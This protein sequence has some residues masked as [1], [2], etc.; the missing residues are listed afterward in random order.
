MIRNI[1]GK[2]RSGFL[3]FEKERFKKD[4]VISEIRKL[5]ADAK[6]F[7]NEF[8]ADCKEA[9]GTFNKIIQDLNGYQKDESKAAYA[10]VFKIQAQCCN[11]A[12]GVINKMS[13]MHAASIREAIQYDINV[14]H[15]FQ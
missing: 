10:E 7:M 9:E 12:I 5:I 15:E 3:G 2:W 13:S 11:K 1:N 14:L 6:K 4:Q 8:T